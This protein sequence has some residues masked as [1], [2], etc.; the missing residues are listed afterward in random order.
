MTLA[1]LLT[2]LTAPASA[3]PDLV[4]PPPQRCLPGPMFS[5][6]VEDPDDI[7][8]AGLDEAQVASALEVFLPQTRRC[9][10]DSIPDDGELMV[11][12]D[13]SCG[14]QVDG[15]SVLESA[16]LAPDVVSCVGETLQ[17]TPFPAHDV[18][19]GVSVAYTVRFEAPA[20]RQP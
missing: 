16:E 19:T 13:V 4:R 6:L 7:V 14:G 20:R 3:G 18:P 12:L 9:F 17:Y 5:H 1:L 11:L 10:P 2:A 8:Y 15:V